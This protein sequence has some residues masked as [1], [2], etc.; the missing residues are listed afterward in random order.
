ME[1]FQVVGAALMGLLLSVTPI[2]VLPRLYWSKLLG[3][4]EEN[5]GP[6]LLISFAVFG[7]LWA[8]LPIAF[9]FAVA[10]SN[11]LAGVVFAVAMYWN[12]LRK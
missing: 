5:T 12:I 10:S 4:R 1:A 11:A 8:A 3:L 7:A 9:I 2:P 6:L